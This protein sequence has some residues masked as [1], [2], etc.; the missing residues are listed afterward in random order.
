MLR[1]L[2]ASSNQVHQDRDKRQN[3][4]EDNPS[5]LGP[6]AHVMALKISEKI[7]INSYM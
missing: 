3:E 2:S 4:D 7:M 6:T 1:H 5:R